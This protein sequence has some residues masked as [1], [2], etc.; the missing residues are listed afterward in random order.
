MDDLTSRRQLA[1]ARAALRSTQD[2]HDRIKA[3]T[4]QAV[5]AQ[6]GGPKQLGVNA[7]D[8]ERALRIVL[9]HDPAYLGI[10]TPCASGRPR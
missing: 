2:D 8:R 1:T 5:I 9:E 10:W 7:E 4:E 6:V 3:V